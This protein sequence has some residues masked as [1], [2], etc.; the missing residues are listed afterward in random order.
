MLRRVCRYSLG[1]WSPPADH[2]QLGA[3]PAA[4]TT[5]RRAG[6]SGT[7]RSLVVAALVGLDLWSKGAVS[8]GS[9]APRGRPRSPRGLSAISD[10]QSRVAGLHAQS[11][12][13]GGI[14][15]GRQCWGVPA[16]AAS[17]RSSS[18]SHRRDPG[19]P[20]CT[21]RPWSSYRGPWQLY[22]SLLRAPSRASGYAGAGVSPGSR[23]STCAPRAGIGTSRPSTSPIHHLGGAVLLLLSGFFGEGRRRRRGLAKAS[24]RV[25]S[26]GHLPAESPAAGVTSAFRGSN[27]R[28]RAPRSPHRPS[29][30]LPG[31]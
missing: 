24:I 18:R 7:R 2:G 13:Q 3:P 4:R 11:Q 19:G 14:R 20:A 16:D 25:A 17:Q 5:A 1:S 28:C 23:P 12:L 26:C 10:P 29:P 6:G 30:G 21:S 27:L 9:T 22:D 15:A 8:D 31:R